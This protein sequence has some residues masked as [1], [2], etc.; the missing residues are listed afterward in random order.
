M[1]RRMRLPGHHAACCLIVVSALMSG[2]ILQG[3]TTPASEE[4]R[5]RAESLYVGVNAEDLPDADHEAQRQRK[6]ETDRQYRVRSRGRMTVDKITY[7]SVAGDLDIP[8]YLFQ[9]LA[10]GAGSN[11]AAMIWV[12]GGVHDDWSL[13]MLPFVAEAVGRNYII[14]APEYRGST[15]YGETF[16]KA[17]DYGGAELQDVLGAVEYL[18]SLPHVDPER[19][20]ILGWSHGGFIASHLLFREDTPFRAGAAIVPVTNLVFRLSALG[21]TYQRHFAPQP[22][23]AGLPFE[24]LERYLQRSPVHHVDKLS[25]PMLVHIATNDRDVLL[26]ESEQLVNALR[27]K[28]PQLADTRV[29]LDPPGGHGFDRRVAGDSLLPVW[30]PEQRDSWSRVWTFFEWWLRPYACL[31]CPRSTS[32]PR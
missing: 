10:I 1:S 18:K 12:H 16:Y 19:I 26:A 9:P 23:F 17:I 7:R 3:Q 28:R 29:Y 6:A 32:D 13:S 2:R 22:A 4:K 24:R 14:I 5:L 15:G 27:A 20:G 11:F 25:V 30:T 31:G 21:P 8:A